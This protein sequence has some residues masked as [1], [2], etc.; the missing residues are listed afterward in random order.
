MTAMEAF[1]RERFERA[2]LLL[3]RAQMEGETMRTGPTQ[4]VRDMAT[5]A[6]CRTVD[7][8][9]EVLGDLETR[10]VLGALVQPAA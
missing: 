9:V 10:G 3:R 2:R 8:L 1:D 6:Y 7:Q 5:D 4:P